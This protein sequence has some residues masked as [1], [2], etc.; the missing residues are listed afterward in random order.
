MNSWRALFLLIFA[1]LAS[2]SLGA[3]VLIYKGTGK[4]V[5]KNDAVVAGPLNVYVLIDV[6]TRQV[7][8]IYFYERDNQKLKFSLSPAVYRRVTF[9]LDSG[10]TSGVY[11]QTI[12]LEV[13]E[14]Y[15][16]ATRT[17]RGTYAGLK[18]NSL[19]VTPFLHPKSISGIEIIFADTDDSPKSS[20]VRY[21]VSFQQKRTIEANDG[22]QTILQVY[23][24][25]LAELEDKGF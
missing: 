12:V 8:T 5:G 9:P 1:G 18:V 19:S 20:D 14:Q 2:T 21:N 4:Q 7:S 6:A 23:N 25:L 13:N 22:N 11:N 17:L 3:P 24:A 10:K 16:L 15:L